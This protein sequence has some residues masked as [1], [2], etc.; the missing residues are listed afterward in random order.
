MPRILL[1][2]DYGSSAGQEA[3]ELAALA[4]LRLDAWEA[5]VLEHALGEGPDGRWAAAEVG[6]CVPRQNGKNAVLEARELAGLFLLGE[7]LII[8]SAQQFKTAREHFLR[9]VGLVEGTAKLSR[10][11]KRVIRSHGEEGIEMLNGQR[12]LFLAR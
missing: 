5:L 7:E 8:H 1:A 11:V 12:I 10:R 3:V 6:L 4:G 9:L 2:P